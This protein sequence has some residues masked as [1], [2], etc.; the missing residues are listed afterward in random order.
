MR[1][2]ARNTIRIFQHR[3]ANRDFSTAKLEYLES[4]RVYATRSRSVWY[5]WYTFGTTA[6]RR[7][8]KCQPKLCRALF[9]STKL[10]VFGQTRDTIF[11]GTFILFSFRSSIVF[12]ARG[13]TRGPMSAC[14]K[15]T[16]HARRLESSSS[17]FNVVQPEYLLRIYG[18]A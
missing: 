12:T 10:F 9:A 17:V 1:C 6:N 8:R 16:R 18:F 5:F 7:G 2:I 3:R 4:N 11:P 15:W 13:E 14:A